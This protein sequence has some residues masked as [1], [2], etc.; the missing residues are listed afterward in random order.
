M[1]VRPHPFLAQSLPDRLVRDAWWL[2]EPTLANEVAPSR[3]APAPRDATAIPVARLAPP[4]PFSTG[5]IRS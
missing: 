4:A 3:L 5:T 2:A 1:R